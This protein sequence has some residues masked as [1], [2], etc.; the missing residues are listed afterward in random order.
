MPYVWYVAE[1]KKTTVY[2]DDADDQRLARVARR[3]GRSRAELIREAVARLLR[4]EGIEA[5]PQFA[6]GSSTHRD[7][8]S[9]VDEALAEEGFGR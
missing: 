5:S 9:R 7:T 1:M 3:R 6:L 2:L 8:S 4:E